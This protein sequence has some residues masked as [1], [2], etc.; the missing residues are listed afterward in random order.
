[1]KAVPSLFFFKYKITSNSVLC[2][3]HDEVFFDAFKRKQTRDLLQT[4]G[5]MYKKHTLLFLLQIVVQRKKS[6]RHHVI[7]FL[8]KPFCISLFCLHP[9]GFSSRDDA[10]FFLQ[11][12]HK[13]LHGHLFFFCANGM[14]NVSFVWPNSM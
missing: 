1:M 3:R 14:E 9:T 10:S 2:Q 7:C 12:A 11:S 4:T 8:K 13:L 6:H 5:L